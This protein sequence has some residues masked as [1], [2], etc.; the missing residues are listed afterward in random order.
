MFV[1]ATPMGQCWI[2]VDLDGRTKLGLSKLGESLPFERSTAEF[3]DYLRLPPKKA[4]GAGPRSP[5][6]EQVKKWLVHCNGPPKGQA[7][8]I[9]GISTS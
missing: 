8:Y 2:V 9:R 4:S 1:D 5:T 7:S 3:I 6:E